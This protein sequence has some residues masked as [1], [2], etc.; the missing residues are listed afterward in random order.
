MGTKYLLRLTCP[1]VGVHEDGDAAGSLEPKLRPGCVVG[2]WVLDHSRQDSHGSENV[3][4]LRQGHCLPAGG[5]GNVLEPRAGLGVNH[6]ERVY[7]GSALIFRREVDP[8]VSRVV[9]A[10]VA[11][12]D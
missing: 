12:A 8:S 10:L 2:R 4:G 6:A 1:L 3:I 11:P 7:R 9:P 5:I